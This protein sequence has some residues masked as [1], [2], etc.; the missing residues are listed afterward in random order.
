MLINRIETF[1]IFK[2]EIISITGENPSFKII[3]T[4]RIP[5]DAMI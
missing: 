3:V 2:Q 5:Y 1:I 4:I